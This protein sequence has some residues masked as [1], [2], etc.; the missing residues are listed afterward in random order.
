MTWTPSCL[1]AVKVARSLLIRFP[2]LVEKYSKWAKKGLL[3]SIYE[4][5]NAL[6]P[7]YI[8][9]V[10]SKLN[11]AQQKKMSGDEREP[12]QNLFSK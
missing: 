7:G 12:S 8:P 2:G 5:E 3:S 10:N 9:D 1:S 4:F 6:R 11:L